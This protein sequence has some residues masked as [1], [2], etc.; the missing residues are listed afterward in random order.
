MD[1]NIISK[2]LWTLLYGMMGIFGVMG[3]IAIT[4]SILNHFSKKNVE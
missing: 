2:S 4:V 1:M 3:I